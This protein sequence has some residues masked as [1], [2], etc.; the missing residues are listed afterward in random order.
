[1]KEIRY[2]SHALDRMTER[3]ISQKL[4]EV[5]LKDADGEIQQSFDKKIY[6]KTVHGRKD[7]LIALVAIEKENYFDMI[8]VMIN[9]EV[10]DEHL[11]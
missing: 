4:V 9:F 11:S 6:F 10:N 2:R 1:M 3:K 7:N 5:I 8:T